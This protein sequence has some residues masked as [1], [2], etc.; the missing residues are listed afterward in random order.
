MLLMCGCTVNINLS[1]DYKNSKG[2]ID[3]TKEMVEETSNDAPVSAS[4]G[5]K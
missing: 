4:T 2:D 5:L 3:E 1:N